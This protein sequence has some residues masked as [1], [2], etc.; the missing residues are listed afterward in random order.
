MIGSGVIRRLWPIE[1][2]RVRGH[3]LRL[4]PDGRRLRFGGLVGPAQIEA[5]CA[6]LDW[7]RGAI[8]GY[9]E[10]GAVRGV[11]ELLPAAEGGSGTAELAV[12]VEPR[13]QNRG[14]GTALLRRLVVAARNR[15]IGR[16]TMVC[17]ID[18]HRAV[19]MA[20]RFEGRLEI[21]RGEALARIEPPWPTWWTLLEE[22]FD[23]APVML[24]RDTAARPAEKRRRSISHREGSAASK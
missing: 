2:E 13:W 1:G 20:R 5:H 22:T 12:S 15:L 6:G 18:N 16:L 24:R 4:D 10:A 3:L 8:I 17:L 9:L 23:G 7:R 21:D 11:G 14:I 19:R